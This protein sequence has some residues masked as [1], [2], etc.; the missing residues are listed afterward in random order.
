MVRR[1]TPGL[2]VYF[3]VVSSTS[4][5][6]TLR[7]WY[8]LVMLWDRR[9]IAMWERD[10]STGELSSATTTKLNDET[11]VGNGVIVG[12]THSGTTLFASMAASE[13][14]SRIVVLDFA[15]G[16]TPPPTVSPTPAPTLG[17]GDMLWR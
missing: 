7:Y 2:S 10:A 14:D 1:F 6:L 17:K 13:A 15:C 5:F 9:Q 4:K 12:M 11:V 16:S 8:I 3:C